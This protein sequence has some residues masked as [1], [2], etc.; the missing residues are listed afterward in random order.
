MK[1]KFLNAALAG[2]IL[3]V[4]S[5]ANVA[6]AGVI[7][8]RIDSSGNVSQIDQNR[9]FYNAFSN[10]RANGYWDLNGSA[11]TISVNGSS[12][13]ELNTSLFSVADITDML[14]TYNDTAYVKA[15]DSLYRIDSSGN[16]SQ[17]DQNIL[18]YNAFSNNMANGYWILNGSANTISVNGSSNTV[19]NTSLFSVADITDMLYTYN[20]TAYV[21]AVDSLFR[22]D[23]SGNVN[24][25]DQNI[26]FYNAFSNNRANGY[27]ILNGNTN[28]ISVNGS[29]NTVLNTSLFSISD[30]TDMSYTYNDTAYVTVDVP[31]P[32]TFFIFALGVMGLVSYRFKKQA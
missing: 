11:N 1:F 22:I 32:S 24:Q 31:E 19:L 6:N 18:F 10:N 4:S 5:L 16:V 13:T 14:Y 7:Q 28:T 27:W 29:S 25:I 8:Y 17:V 2:F 3:S 15:V 23:S 12:N 26:S 30:I 9:T 20:D 21:K